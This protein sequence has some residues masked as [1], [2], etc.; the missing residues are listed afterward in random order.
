M[1]FQLCSLKTAHSSGKHSFWPCGSIFRSLFF[2]HSWC[3]EPLKWYKSKR[4]Y[5]YLSFFLSFFL[6]FLVSKVRLTAQ[7]F[8]AKNVFCCNEALMTRVDFAQSL[9]SVEIS[10]SRLRETGAVGAYFFSSLL[11]RE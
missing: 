8:L 6:S 2:R 5:P 10:I 7:F 9:R 11:F 3:F 4:T 1:G